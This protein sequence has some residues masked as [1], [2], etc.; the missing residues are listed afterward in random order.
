[1]VGA[2]ET[3]TLFTWNKIYSVGNE[4]MDAQ[5]QRLFEIANRFH[6]AFEK[7]LGTSTLCAIFDELVDYTQTHFAEEEQLMRAGHYPDFDRHK[8]NHEK[9]VG[10]VAWYREALARGEPGIEERAMGFIRTWLTG[11]ILG[12]DTKYRDY[13]E[14]SGGPH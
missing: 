6:D 4:R 11:H 2:G 12:M 7:K 1:M 10:L 3:M 9:L 13:V 5:H 8:E 14:P